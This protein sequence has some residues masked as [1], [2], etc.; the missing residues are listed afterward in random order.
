[1]LAGRELTLEAAADRTA[2]PRSPLFGPVPPPLE[3][4]CS[5]L[6]CGLLVVG[7]DVEAAFGMLQVVEKVLE[8]VQD[9][10]SRYFLRRPGDTSVLC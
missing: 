2:L 7:G 8:P 1:L 4:C 3:I 5:P 6:S 9:A 10:L